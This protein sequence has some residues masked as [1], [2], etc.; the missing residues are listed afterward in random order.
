MVT[1]CLV[2]IVIGGIGACLTY[3]LLCVNEDESETQY[4][5]PEEIE[6]VEKVG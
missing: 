3:W 6:L 5:V 2:V 4:N 1:I